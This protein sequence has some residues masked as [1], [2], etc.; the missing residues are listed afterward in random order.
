MQCESAW[1][2]G[3]LSELK[4]AGDPIHFRRAEVPRRAALETKADKF[5]ELAANAL[6]AWPKD[7]PWLNETDTA[8][9]SKQVQ[10]SKTGRR[11]EEREKRKK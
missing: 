11:K 3:R 5:A 9:F 2:R 7:K 10:I 6:A 8:A 1:R 4:K